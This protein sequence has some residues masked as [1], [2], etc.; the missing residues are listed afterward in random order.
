MVVF[1]FWEPLHYL[2]RGHAFQTWETSPEFS[3]RSW[4]YVLLHLWPGKLANFMFGPEKVSASTVTLKLHYELMDSQ[5][6]AFFAIRIFL[7]FIS[8][9]SEAFFYRTVVDKINY[10]AGRYLLFMMLFNAGMWNAS[11]GE[12][13]NIFS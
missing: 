5:R 10:R 13:S 6:P 3:I 9:T 1:N 12:L 7:A 8:A 2:H 4:A 11:V